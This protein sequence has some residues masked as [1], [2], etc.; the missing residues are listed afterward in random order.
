MAEDRSLSEKLADVDSFERPTLAKAVVLASILP[1]AGVGALAAD[2]L[3]LEY[4]ARAAM[5]MLLTAGFMGATFV[6]VALVD[7][8]VWGE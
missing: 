3:P 2:S 7:D 6:A 1:S 8:A 4:G 5:T